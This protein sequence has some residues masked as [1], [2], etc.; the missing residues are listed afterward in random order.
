M[1]ETVP[2]R[3]LLFR[4][5]FVLKCAEKKLKTGSRKNLHP[6]ISSYGDFAYA[7][8]IVEKPLTLNS[9]KVVLSDG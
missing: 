1:Y 7:R 9:S 8:E 6:K 5:H 2:A 3:A 4:T